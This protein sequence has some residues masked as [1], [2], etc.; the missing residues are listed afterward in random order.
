MLNGSNRV[1]FRSF[2]FDSGRVR[3]SLSNFRS[4]SI[5]V[6]AMLQTPSIDV[7]KAISHDI[8]STDLSP[9]LIVNPIESFPSSNIGSEE[10][11]TGHPSS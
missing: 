7:N 8:Y 3:V 11:I 10:G 6:K 2:G 9:S 1:N 4:R 5:R